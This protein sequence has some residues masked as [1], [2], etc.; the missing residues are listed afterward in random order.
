MSTY[1]EAKVVSINAAREACQDCQLRKLCLGFALSAEELSEL[2]SVVKRQRCLSSGQYL[3]RQGDPFDYVHVV[4]TGSLKT[5]S[6]A[7][8][9]TEQV[10]GFYLPG[11]LTG[12]DAISTGTYPCAAQALE[13]TSVCLIRYTKLEE[14]STAIPSLRQSLVHLMSRALYNN[15]QHIASLGSKSA[16]MR[17]AWFLTRFS[18]RFKERGYSPSEFY[19]RMSRGDIGNYL[20]LAMETV[21]RLFRRFQDLGLIAVDRRLI[22]I[23]DLAALQSFATEPHYACKTKVVA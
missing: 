21:S 5:Y 3:Y 15:E 18:E 11:E 7:S 1:N 20:G 17:F 22:R 14:L 2:D 19:L 13:N 16:E 6:L 12:L 10:T 8:D 4:R 23:P 9:G